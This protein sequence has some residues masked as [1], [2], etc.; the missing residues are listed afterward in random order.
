MQLI[1]LRLS[2]TNIAAETV[3]RITIN[4]LKCKGHTIAKLEVAELEVGFTKEFVLGRALLLVMLYLHELIER[5]LEHRC[6]LLAHHREKVVALHLVLHF[7]T[8]AQRASTV[9]STVV[10]LVSFDAFNQI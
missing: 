6:R 9:T 7:W 10:I 2:K 5:A 3:G 1:L 8:A 4:L